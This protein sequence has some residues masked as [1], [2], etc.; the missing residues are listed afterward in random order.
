MTP[1]GQI[2]EKELLDLLLDKEVNDAYW[3]AFESL[4]ERILKFNIDYS[5][6]KTLIDNYLSTPMP[7]KPP[8][9]NIYNMIDTVRDELLLQGMPYTHEHKLIEKILDKE[10]QIILKGEYG[11][12]K[13]YKLAFIWERYIKNA[14]HCFR[15]EKNECIFRGHR[16][17]ILFDIDGKDLTYK[18]ELYT[19]VYI[20]MFTLYKD[21]N[22]LNLYFDDFISYINK[23][24]DEGSGYNQEIEYLSYLKSLCKFNN[25]KYDI[26][27]LPDK[28]D[29]FSQQEIRDLIIFLFHFGGWLRN[30]KCENSLCFHIVFDNIDSTSKPVQEAILK[31]LSFYK[32][33]NY[34]KII[35]A[36]RPETIFG[37]KNRDSVVDVFPHKGPSAHKVILHIF[38]KHIK[39][40][41]IDNEK[42]QKGE[43]DSFYRNNT[44]P[45]IFSLD[46]YSHTFNYITNILRK[47]YF[48]NIYD[49][50]F[51]CLIRTAKIFTQGLIDIAANNAAENK[52]KIDFNNRYLS[53]SEYALERNFYRPWGLATK[54]IQITNIFN[55]CDLRESRLSAIR[56]LAIL[57]VKK[58]AKYMLSID[59]IMTILKAYGYTNDL[60]MKTMNYLIMEKFILAKTRELLELPPLR[61]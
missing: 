32:P 35:C 47:E 8:K 30:N 25:G 27:L 46:V 19:Y 59:K 53:K 11:S 14:R 57:N 5:D 2:S 13:T 61:I 31:L 33:L 9:E 37:R 56:I 10:L 36:C 54:K 4:R 51:Y 28:V 40:I 42:E 26:R 23:F 50:Y 18:K 49:D 3:E 24:Y 52:S 55:P 48:E 6:R 15:L 43:L 17:R 60:L 20:K 38:D 58:S 41:E 44:Y 29:S 22:L 16:Q 21:Y 39:Q 45:G 12:G 1:I 34:L 7:I